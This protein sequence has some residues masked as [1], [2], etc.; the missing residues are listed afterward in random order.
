LKQV[1]AQV[2]NQEGR[3]LSG[4]VS[5]SARLSRFVSSRGSITKKATQLKGA[6]VWHGTWFAAR[7]DE[8][9]FFVRPCFKA[10][11]SKVKK[12][13]EERRTPAVLLLGTPGTGKT[14]FLHYVAEQLLCEGR[15]IVID[16]GDEAILVKDG[17]A[18][19]A[20]SCQS[21]NQELDDPHTVLL[22]DCCT[23]R[24][25]PLV[26]AKI[27]ATSSPN[28][29]R[30]SEFD[31]EYCKTLY[32]PLWSLDELSDCRQSCFV[33]VHVDSLLDRF[34]KWGGVIRWTIGSGCSESDEQFAKAMS[35]MDFDGAVKAVRARD[36]IDPKDVKLTHR[37]I[38]AAVSDDFESWYFQFCSQH[39]CEIVIDRLKDSANVKC[40]EFLAMADQD[41]LFRGL[42]GQ[43]FESFAHRTLARGGDF[44]VRLNIGSGWRFRSPSEHWLGVVISKSV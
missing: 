35:N 9:N 23:Q 25:P 26:R 37:I 13:W 34:E 40:K 16:I 44:E 41:P 7:A 4:E 24:Q 36:G 21:F 15:T 12:A 27:L 18:S 3:R 33:D 38:H 42:Q 39:A 17:Q 28:R 22:F 32:M 30:Y 10:L 6:E 1:E 19:C 20:V 8:H 5:S 2:G 43:V 29:H 11:F 31:K 14:F